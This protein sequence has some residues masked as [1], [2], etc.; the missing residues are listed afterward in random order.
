MVRVLTLLNF[1]SFVEISFIN[2]Y[3]YALVIIIYSALCQAP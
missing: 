3:C 1:S 2:P